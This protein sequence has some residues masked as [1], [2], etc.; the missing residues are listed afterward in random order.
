MSEAP[1]LTSLAT[2][3]AT[4]TASKGEMGEKER[5][6]GELVEV[7][8][9]DRALS[10]ARLPLLEGTAAPRMAPL[11]VLRMDRLAL[12]LTGGLVSSVSLSSCSS[13]EYSLCQ[14]LSSRWEAELHFAIAN[15]KRV[16]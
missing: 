14:K 2:P 10:H 13:V 15:A 12:G 4:S 16:C 3:S 11:V 7:E 1:S 6:K 8:G 9:R 5:G